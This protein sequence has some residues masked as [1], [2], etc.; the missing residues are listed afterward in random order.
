MGCTLSYKAATSALA[1]FLM[2]L[3]DVALVSL[4]RG[5]ATRENAIKEHGYCSK[6]PGIAEREGQ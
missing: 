3:D 6:R 1:I 2:A 5:G 4:Q